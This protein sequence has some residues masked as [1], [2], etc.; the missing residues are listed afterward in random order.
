MKYISI[1]LLACAG[2]GGSAFTAADMPPPQGDDADTPM[3]D[4][5]PGD[6]GPEQGDGHK[7][8]KPGPDGGMPA[9]AAPSP[10]ADP[11]DAD[12]PDANPPDAPVDAPVEAAPPVSCPG[13]TTAFCGPAGCDY[14][15]NYC[16]VMNAAGTEGTCTPLPQTCAGTCPPSCDCVT[17]GAAPGFTHCYVQQGSGTILVTYY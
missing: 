15:S 16:A 4:A 2:C 11:P 7:L 6:D 9:D 3:A 14:G 8:G 13:S 10:E 5:A 12:P 1:I 17:A